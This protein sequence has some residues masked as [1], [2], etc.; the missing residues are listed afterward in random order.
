M[1]GPFAEGL[2]APGSGTSVAERRQAATSGVEVLV[3]GVLRALSRAARADLPPSARATAALSL[4]DPC[5]ALV[6]EDG[7][8]SASTEREQRVEFAPRNYR[9]LARIFAALDAVHRLSTSGRSATQRELYYRAAANGDGSLFRC[10][11]DMD[12]A[13]RDAVGALRIG[14]PHLGVLAS[15]KGLVAGAVAF[16]DTQSPGRWSAVRGASAMAITEAMLGNGDDSIE[17][18]SAHCVLVVEKDTFFQNLLQGHLLTCLPLVLVTGRGYPDL[19]TRRF[20]QRLQRTN[21]QLPQVYL[22][23]YDPH[24]VSIFLIYLASCPS[25]RWL[26]M[27]EAHVRG[28]P[29][30]AALPFTPRDHALRASLLKRPEVA[31][32]EQFTAQVSAMDRKFELEALH[33]SHGAEEIALHFVPE[34]ILRRAWL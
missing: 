23:D 1:A 34:K 4:S 11:S 10:Q 6:T 17:V 7:E 5:H 30:Q 21:P 13:V 16:R 26:G 15:E 2:P 14:R 31:G 3:L 12:K 28:L 8:F 27:H 19:L 22:G 20:L 29:E 9:R 18:G 32:N 33:A 24:G 25:M